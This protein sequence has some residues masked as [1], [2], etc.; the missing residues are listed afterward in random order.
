MMHCTACLSYQIKTRR[1]THAMAVTPQVYGLT[2]HV[3][4]GQPWSTLAG[5]ATV[6]KLRDIGVMQRCKNATLSAKALLQHMAVCTS[7]EC[8]DG[9]ALLKLAIETA[10]LIH[11]AHAATRDEPRD[12]IR[13]KWTAHQRGSFA[14]V[15]RNLNNFMIGPASRTRLKPLRQR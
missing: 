13:A 15:L 2:L 12:A 9:N 8:L 11:G 7:P 10:R 6:N 4:H 14:V 1:D 3:L 5:A